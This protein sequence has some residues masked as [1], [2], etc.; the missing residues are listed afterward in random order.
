[1]IKP[2]NVIVVACEEA[3]LVFL[4]VMYHSYA[5]HVVY[6][7]LGGVDADVVARCVTVA[8]E[9]PVK[10]QRPLGDSSGAHSDGKEIFNTNT[11]T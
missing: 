7:L 8:A 3:L 4:D 1:M 10:G 11:H 5:R 6:Q 2:C 9:H